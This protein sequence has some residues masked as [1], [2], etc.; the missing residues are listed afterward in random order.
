MSANTQKIILKPWQIIPSTPTLPKPTHSGYAPINNIK[1]WYAEYGNGPTVILLHGGLVNSNYWGE[2]ISALKDSYHVIILDSRGHGRSTMND[3]PLS[4][5]LMA[6][7]V[8]G[9]MD[10]LKI[11]KA[12]IVGWSDGANIGLDIAITHP[13]RLSKLFALAGNSN[14]NATMDLSNQPSFATFSQRIQDEYIAISPTPSLLNFNILKQHVLKMWETEPNF[15]KKNLESITVPTW[16]VSGDHDE[17]I[18]RSNTELMAR[19]IPTAGLLIEPNSG[20]FVF[21]QHKDKF[22]D[23][24]RHFLKDDHNQKTPR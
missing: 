23:D 18:K 12:A 10:F 13:E 8:L 5:H 16:I 24:V 21:L 2:L 17:A 14:T 4:Y 22:N 6:K 9:L 11:K 15:T 19:T 7:D 1:I 3:E 20:H